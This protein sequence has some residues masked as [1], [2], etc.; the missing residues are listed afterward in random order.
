MPFASVLI[1]TFNHESFIEKAVLSVLEQDLP[2]S[3]REI[4]VVDDGSNDRT[5][6][7]LR[8]FQSQI[9]VIRKKNGGQ[10][11]AFNTGIPEC[12]GEIIAFLDGDDWWA[13]GKLRRVAELMAADSSL[14]M[15]GHAII[16]SF[17]DGY[18]RAVAPSAEKRFRLDSLPSAEFFRS[19][20]CYFGTSRLTLCARLARKIL[21]I[22]ESI[23]IEADEYL[24]TLG[25]AHADSLL[26][27]DPLTHYR[28]HGAN[29]FMASSALP[30][31]ELRKARSLAALVDALR[32]AL[33][34]AGVPADAVASVLELV[35][36]EATQL[37]LQTQGGFSWDTYRTESTLYRIQ[38]SNAPW[39]SGA[40][41]ALSMIP[42][43]LLPPRWFYS[44]RRWLGSRSWY[45]RARRDLIPVPQLVKPAAPPVTHNRS[46][47]P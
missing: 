39:K 3:D 34:A 13:Q 32:T 47:R 33:P 30:G 40:F 14:G 2:A 8:K 29:L 43:L 16:E 18:E 31:G 11:S 21:P 10:A 45:K 46:T 6:E 44:G 41:R 28:I 22:P 1:D 24:F 7:I 19:N 12:R 37:R 9:R 36:A 27:T 42:A 38:H 15:I 25:A 4:I 35:H 26:L 5:P 23:I 20:R 17:N